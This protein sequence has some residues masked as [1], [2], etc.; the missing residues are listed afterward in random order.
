MI[1]GVGVDLIDPQRVARLLTRYGEHFARKVLASEEWSQYSK[2]SKPA[3]FLAKRFAAKEA[4]SKALG[5]GLRA[6]VTLT[7]IRVLQDRLGKP[8][9]A[10][11]PDLEVLLQERGVHRHHLSLSD[12]ANL[13]CAFV[14]LEGFVQ[15]EVET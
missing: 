15:K 1:R 14:V 3:L 10:F 8:R 4:L 5:T 2:S 6:P 13:V 7:R 11:H 12:E 9:F